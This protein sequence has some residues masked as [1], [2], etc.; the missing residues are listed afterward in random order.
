MATPNNQQGDERGDERVRQDARPDRDAAHGEGEDYGTREFGN[1]DWNRSREN[2]D[3]ERR[4]MI[5]NIL[6]ETMLPGLPR[7]K[8]FHRCWVSTNHPSDTP[9]RRMRLGYTVLMMDQIKEAGWAADIHSV[10]DGGFKGAVMWREM[11]GMECPEDLFVDIM[12]ELHHDMPREMQKA[13]VEGMGDIGDRAKD[14]GGRVDLDEGFKEMVQFVRP[15]R[16]FQT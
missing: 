13:I 7:R 4:R 5:R 9:H 14:S 1:S 12:R 6:Q 15:P 8:G 2:T 16:Q 10:K 11:L 3:P